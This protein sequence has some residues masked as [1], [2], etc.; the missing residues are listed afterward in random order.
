MSKRMIWIFGAVVLVGVIA[1]YAWSHRSAESSM[2]DGAVISHDAP[3][4]ETAKMNQGAVDLDGNPMGSSGSTSTSISRAATGN[5]GSTA[6]APS[7]SAPSAVS[8]TLQSMRATPAPAS[9]P[10]A[11]SQSENAPDGAR[12]GGGK[13]Q[14]YRQGNITWRINTQSGSM[15][16]AF[17][18]MEEWQKPIVYSHGC[19]NA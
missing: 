19:G 7:P 11:D 12:F 3:A 4:G 6:I 8:S 18:T 13:F 1:W 16:I 17:A 9:I 2:D 14:W 5:T 15:C 10:V